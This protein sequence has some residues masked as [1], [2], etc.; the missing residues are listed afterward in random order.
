MLVEPRDQENE[1]PTLSP[2][3]LREPLRPGGKSVYC[4]SSGD[5]A[6]NSSSNVTEN[7][8]IGSSSYGASASS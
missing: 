3:T 6:A 1:Y 8:P 4:S 2:L 7:D 5:E